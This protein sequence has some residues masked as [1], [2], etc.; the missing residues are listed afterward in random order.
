MPTYGLYGAYYGGYFND[1]PAWFSEGVPGNSEIRNNFTRWTYEETP[2]EGS[3]LTTGG[4]SIQYTGFFTS[5]AT[6]LH[7]FEL[8]TDDAGYLWIGPTAESGYT[9][10]NAL[11]NLGGI[12]GYYTQ[13]ANI[14]LT[15]GVP[16]FIRLQVGNQASGYYNPGE[17]SLGYKFPG[18]FSFTYN[19]INSNVY[20]IQQ[21]STPTPT[22]TSTLPPGTPTPTPT[23]TPTP[24]PTPT[25]FPPQ[26][27]YTR[28]TNQTTTYTN[29]TA[30][31]AL[32]EGTRTKAAATGLSANNVDL[33][34]LLDPALYP[35][36]K[37]DYNTGFSVNGVD[38]K[39]IF[40]AN[41]ISVTPTPTPTPTTTGTP[42]PTLTPTPTP[43]PTPLPTSTPAPT[44]PP[45]PIPPTVNLT[46]NGTKALGQTVNFSSTGATF[47]GRN[48]Y[49]HIIW[50]RSGSDIN[51]LGTWV[52]N[53]IAYPNA[54]SSNLSNVGSFT[55]SFVGTYQFYAAIYTNSGLYGYSTGIQT[56]NIT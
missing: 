33:K 15:Q 25:P 4:L 56:F 10:S 52:A 23:I 9:T 28:R 12:H 1:N 44:S 21:S 26:G 13:T 6:G 53:Y 14:T 47:D 41:G 43:T 32:Y 5:S 42:S 55:F 50:E 36:E 8:G 46:V 20:T 48:I 29:L 11:I 3:G 45:L 40:R 2:A 30:V 35:G 39:D 18:Q 49:S 38:L 16:Y 31:F 17:L 27:Y 22:P 24:T 51:N 19:A 54:T 7:T 34:D 37:I